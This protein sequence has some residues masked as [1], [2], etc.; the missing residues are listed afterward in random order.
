MKELIIGIFLMFSTV[1]VFAS[2]NNRLDMRQ[3][4]M[5]MKKA[6]SRATISL[7]CGPE[8]RS[9]VQDLTATLKPTYESI[10]AITP[11]GFD[12]EKALNEAVAPLGCKEAVLSEIESGLLTSEEALAAAASAK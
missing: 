9:M 2:D 8:G 1:T 12:V 7:A 6:A 11:G 5:E 4:E 3:L 10:D